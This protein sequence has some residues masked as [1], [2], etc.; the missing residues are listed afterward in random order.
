MATATTPPGSDR[1]CWKAE[2]QRRVESIEN[3]T[4]QMYTLDVTLEHLQQVLDEDSKP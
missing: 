3:G 1:E 2:L 4:M